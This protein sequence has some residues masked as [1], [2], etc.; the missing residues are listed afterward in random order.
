MKKYFFLAAIA[1]LA[2]ASCSSDETIASQAN[3]EA[4]EISFRPLM[5]NVTRASSIDA[6]SGIN[7][8]QT[9]GFYV[10][11]TKTSDHSVYFSD[12]LYKMQSANLWKPYNT[13]SSSYI[14]IYWP[15]GENVLDFHAYAPVATIYPS[16]SQLM[17]NN[18]SVGTLNGC[19]EYTVTPSLSASS[20]I[21]FIYATITDQDKDNGS[22]PLTFAHKESQV[23]VQLK[24]TD[25]ALNF[26]VS[27]V[28]I[29]NIKK[30]GVFKYRTT[31]S[32]GMAWG[33]LGEKDDYG[34]TGLSITKNGEQI[35][36]LAGE[37]WILIPQGLATPTTDGEYTSSSEY[38]TYNGAYIKVKYKCQNNADNSYYA[39]SAESWVEGI[40]PISTNASATTWAPGYNYTYT[41]D[42]KGGGYYKQNDNSGTA[43]LKR[44]LNLSE[45]TF[46][47][48][49]V[50]NWTSGGTT[51]V[52]M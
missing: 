33:D 30:S 27:E 12:Q 44:I 39:G 9:I 29:C 22:M 42:L 4:N 21:D 20:Q 11:A 49:T 25:P 18:T 3:S 24:N 23:G 5:N 43:A 15:T 7:G 36:T 1:V 45:I 47:T 48:V 50:S 34:Q 17:I 51:D 52:G 14:H 35:A 38:A 31:P 8:L 19:P 2:L 28:S 6:G 16:T 10:T 46:A 40:W 13:S 26:T 37:T 41:I 32:T